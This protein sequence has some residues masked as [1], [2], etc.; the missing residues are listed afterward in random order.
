MTL[1]LVCIP[2]GRICLALQPTRVFHGYLDIHDIHDD[3]DI[4]RLVIPK[5]TE[6]YLM[7]IF[8]VC[9]NNVDGKNRPMIPLIVK[10]AYEYN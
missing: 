6:S 2:I 5:S 7:E 4:D 3:H 10:N 9:F 1:K 8:S